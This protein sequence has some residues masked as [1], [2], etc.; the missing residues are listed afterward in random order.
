MAVFHLRRFRPAMNL[1]N[2]E[3]LSKARCINVAHCH[4]TL[5]IGVGRWELG[6]VRWALPVHVLRCV[7]RWKCARWALPVH[8]N[9]RWELGNARWA[10]PVHVVRQRWVLR[11]QV[12]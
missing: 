6:N 12:E 10:L 1:R 11:M 5:K 8:E 9:Q 3:K 4:C 7:A 2:S